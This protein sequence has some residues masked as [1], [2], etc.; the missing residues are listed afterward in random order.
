MT[1]RSI[2]L[3]LTILAWP[4]GIV[5]ALVLFLATGIPS[6]TTGSPASGSVRSV[7]LIEAQPIGMTSVLLWGLVALGPG[8]V[9]T[10]FYWI[11]RPRP[12]DES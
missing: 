1:R 6:S 5:F 7:A 2:Q 10:I 3:A 9:A 11:T 4:A 8:I 12:D